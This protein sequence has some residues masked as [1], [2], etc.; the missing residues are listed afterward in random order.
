MSLKKIFFL[1]ILTFFICTSYSSSGHPS[2][3]RSVPEN[4]ERDVSIDSEIILEFSHQI[5]KKSITKSSLTLY[6]EYGEEIE[7][8]TAFDE[9]GFKVFIKPV[10]SLYYGS[11]YNIILTGYLIKNINGKSLRNN[12]NISFQTL[13][14]AELK[15]GQTDPPRLISRYPAADAEK[16]PADARILLTFNK[17]IKPS[18]IN[19]FTFRVEDMHGEKVPGTFKYSHSL[20]RASFSPSKPLENEMIYRV[21]LTTGIT[22]NHNNFLINPETWRFKVEPAPDKTPPFITS[23]SPKDNAKDV[24]INS[25]LAFVFNEPI[26]KNTINT[27]NIKLI[28]ST[29]EEEVPV[30]IK[31]SSVSFRTVI[32]P[33]EELQ[34]DTHYKISVSRS[35]KDKSGNYM[36]HDFSFRFHTEEE[37]DTTPPEITSTIPTEDRENFKIDNQIVLFFSKP[38]DNSTLN[39]ET[40]KLYKIGDKKT[41]INKMVLYNQSETKVVI[42]P[43]KDLE[44]KTLYRLEADGVR[45]LAGNKLKELYSLE[46]KTELPPDSS[47]PFVK[48]IQPENASFNISI[49][50]EVII[51]MSEPVNTKTVSNKSIK[52]IKKETKER[53]YLNFNLEGRETD[54]IKF[55]PVG[56]LE[57]LTSYILIVGPEIADGSGNMMEEEHKIR[58]TTRRNPDIIPPEVV[59]IK[60]EPNSSNVSINSVIELTFSEEL[61]VESINP[62]S[63]F[64]FEGKNIVDCDFNYNENNH[65]ITMRPVN[66]LNY[67]TKYKILVTPN[68]KDL[69]GN[70]FNEKAW[71]FLAERPPDTTAPTVLFTS[72]V[73]NASN[74]SVDT[75]ITATFSKN[76][77]ADTLKF[78][79]ND[80]KN[81]I[82][83][84]VFYDQT[85]KRAILEPETKLMFDNFYTAIIEKT[86][87]DKYGN[88]M[89]QDKVWNFTVES[90]PDTTP[91][92][93]LYFEPSAGR[94]NVALD[95]HIKINFSKS[96]KESTINEYSVMLSSEEG[97]KIPGTV[98]YKSEQNEL[99]FYP[100]KK[101]DYNTE[102][103]FVI[104]N[105]VRCAAGNNLTEAFKFSFKTKKAPDTERPYIKSH[106]PERNHK[107]IPV[108]QKIAIRFS[109]QMD[110]ESLNNFTIKLS[111]EE[112]GVAVNTDI[113]YDSD[114]KEALIIPENK[115]YYYTNYIVSVSRIVRDLSGNHMKSTK[116]FSFQ[117]EPEPDNIPPEIIESYPEDKDEKIGINDRF[118]I[119]FSEV[120]LEKSINL[121][122][123][124]LKDNEGSTIRAK[125][126]FLEDENLVNII[127]AQTLEYEKYYSIHITE[128]SDLAGNVVESGNIIEFKTESLPDLEPPVIVKF[129]PKNLQRDVSVEDD[130]ILEFSKKLDKETVNNKNIRLE[131]RSKKIDIEIFYNEEENIAEIKPDKELEYESEYRMLV[132]SS[133]ACKSGNPL[134]KTYIWRFYTEETPDRTKPRLVNITP[135]D[136]EE[137]VA[138]TEKI[139]AYFSKP[140]DPESINKY[141]F[142]VQDESEERLPASIEYSEQESQV[143][144]IPDSPLKHKQYKITLT[145]GIN[146]KVGNVLENP[147]EIRFF[148]GNAKE[149][150]PPYIVLTSPENNSA[151]VSTF[152]NISVT[153]SSI[154]DENTI[155]K[156]TLILSDGVSSVK[157]EFVYN[158]YLRRVTFKPEK[159]LKADTT[160]TLTITKS[161]KSK[162][163]LPIEEAE[164]IRF[165]T[166]AN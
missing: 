148:A 3:V 15:G 6:D 99:D 87:S 61:R 149:L 105:N 154:M 113:K 63:I 30:E 82:E 5:D 136:G 37:G 13:S 48:E 102:Y 127:P 126:E 114:K 69:A 166:S 109:K 117:T 27:Q 31:Y 24:S 134:N 129:R 158:E 135:A 45:D 143:V 26:N 25:E 28:K 80:G 160:Y 155:N 32:L 86:T 163:N 18:S 43:E 81:E 95:T 132:S 56:N 112:S 49:S 162:F 151:N 70:A 100:E 152:A 137:N 118:Y 92:S 116:I 42:I 106:F 4:N 62:G 64:L 101:L 120:M 10:S 36:L 164:I 67:D 58:F 79:L 84:E 52:L 85:S 59:D 19:E 2:L 34:F 41:I 44:N 75:M 51:T 123:I 46:F 39:D 50:P 9:K 111:E 22:D 96:M 138:L 157:G 94:D 115:F 144:L 91:P 131:K 103:Q 21:S 146:D 47:P 77:D 35:I 72:P 93:I 159:E 8:T 65:K 68:V 161:I 16:V 90:K 165:K 83:S 1:I 55:N 53:E 140:L 78:R 141:T 110:R 88:E 119:R 14:S 108:N 142:Y 71:F 128:A 54:K 107:R 98:S 76:I 57:Y 7:T 40:I 124:Y 66:L 33:E 74:V 11:N 125:L 133:V 130:I 121:N 29:S 150:T 145:E 38:L 20:K 156:Y 17:E 89:T 60:P 147:M 97:R 139:T 104:N 122:N 73:E 12:Y 153:F 23:T